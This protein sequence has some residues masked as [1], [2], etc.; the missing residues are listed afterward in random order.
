[1]DMSLI[2]SYIGFVW[3]QGKSMHLL[4][5]YK[6]LQSQ[7]TA[8]IIETFDPTKLLSTMQTNVPFIETKTCTLLLAMDSIPVNILPFAI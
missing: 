3:D 1:M 7:S 8:I 2:N 4:L 6:A 5:V